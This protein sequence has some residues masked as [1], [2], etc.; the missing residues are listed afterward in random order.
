MINKRKLLYTFFDYRA[1]RDRGGYW[2]AY[3]EQYIPISRIIDYFLTFIT[4]K[5]AI[6][7]NSWFWAL[8]GGGVFIGYKVFMETIQWIIGKIDYKQGL[9]KT[10]LDWSPKNKKYNVYNI[11]MMETLKSI[12]EKVGADFYFKE[13]EE[14]K[15]DLNE[16]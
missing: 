7:N 1:T 8:V 9:W 5:I 10:E 2:M 15:K 14:I 6:Q 11:E 3:L 12:C 13:L 16:N 4:L